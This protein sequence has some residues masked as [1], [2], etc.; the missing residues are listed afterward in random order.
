MDAELITR[1]QNLLDEANLSGRAASLQAGLSSRFLYELFKG[2]KR[3][4]SIENAEKLAPVLDTTPEWIA[5]GHGT[6]RPDGPPS[7]Q[8]ADIWDRIAPRNRRAARRMLEGLAEPK[9]IEYEGE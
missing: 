9:K 1:L 6:K 8:V 2:E 5:F 3:S 4:F 7:S